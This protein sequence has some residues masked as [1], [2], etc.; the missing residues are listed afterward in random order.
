MK[1]ILLLASG[2]LSLGLILIGTFGTH[3]LCGGNE[4]CINVLHYFFIGFLP[5]LPLFLFSLITY[6]MAAS[7][8]RAWV[9]FAAV[10]IPLSMVGILFAPEYVTNMGWFYPVVKGTVAFSTS[11]LFLV[12]SAL[13]VLFAW[14]RQKALERKAGK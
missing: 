11:L 9:R 14:A 6:R 2:V 10:W 12:I 3:T 7:V 4:R 8:Y 13:I 1:K 5:I